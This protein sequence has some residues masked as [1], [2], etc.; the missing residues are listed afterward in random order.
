MED[1]INNQNTNPA[2]P[3]WVDKMLEFFCAPQLL[4]EVQGDMFE[5]YG[6]WVE[7]Y[8]ERKARRLYI[9][10]ALKFFRPFA[11]KKQKKYNATSHHTM[12]KNYFQIAYRNLAKHIGYTAINVI[13]LSVGLTASLFIALYIIHELSYD[14]DH[15]KADRIYRVETQKMGAEGA[16]N[17]PGAPLGVAAA[18]RQD[19]PE[20]EEVSTIIF[21]GN[22]LIS[23]TDRKASQ[24][25]FK[26]AVAFAEPEL[27]E[28]FDYQWVVGNPRTS[29]TEPNS[30]I[31]T[32]SYV[33][34]LFGYALDEDLSSVIGKVIQ[35]NLDHDLKVVGVLEDFAANTSFPFDIIVSMTTLKDL[36]L[37]NWGGW[38]DNHQTYI[39]LAEGTDPR[40]VEVQFPV[41]LEKYKGAEASKERGHRLLPLKE[42]HFSYNY[43]GRQADMNN[44]YALGI[45]GLFLLITA[46]INFINLATA[47]VSKRAKEVGV[48]KVLGSSRSQL[49]GQFMSE[50]VLVTLMAFLMAAGLVS[51]LLP[52][53]SLL[54]DINLSFTSLLRPNF[55]FLAIAVFVLVSLLSGLYPAW[56]LS[57]FR[58]VTAL[59]NKTIYKQKRGFPLR[60]SMVT[61]QFII[62]QVLVIATI[63]AISQMQLF[64]NTD[65]GFDTD[66]IIT[67]ELPKSQPEKL[68]LL[69]HQLLQFAEVKNVSFSFNSA[70]AESNFMGDVVYK[71]DSGEVSIHTQLKLVD[72][73]FLDTYGINL[74]AGKALKEGDTTGQVLVNEVFIRKMGMQHPEEAIGEFID[75]SY[76]RFIITGV[77]KDFHVNSLHQNIDP[78]IIIV[79]PQHYQQAG[80][81]IQALAV[82]NMQSTIQHIQEV[83]SANFPDQLFNYQFL[84]ETL[85]QAYEKENKAMQLLYVFAGIA[86][87][88]S[89]LGLYGLVSF[90]AVQRTKEVGI[91]KILGASVGH[92]VQLFAK[93]FM[94]LVALAFVISVPTGY[95]LMSRW[96]QDFA[97]QTE[98]SWW[99]F[100]LAGTLAMVIALFTVSF[101]SIKAALTNPVDSL[102]NE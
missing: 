68:E 40:E 28:V 98:L 99:I 7:E 31:L 71:A 95:Y 33:R 56:V 8:G 15:T 58:P 10:N 22:Q 24:A 86:I 81:K 30:I 34:K 88:I 57:G 5:M 20:I 26:E 14:R 69:R 11:L 76:P 44:L 3:F 16:N 100:A 72:A 70:S 1:R 97:Y 90:T 60:Q 78:T 62:S 52:Y 36:E 19:F 27:F 45:V 18:L 75:N 43:G 65:L 50:T 17:F 25:K 53:A 101:Q 42:V 93:E 84:D 41:M 74:L 46:C 29:L 82:G 38:S 64:R 66:A 35:L 91:R 39:V 2:P 4:E 59:K 94:V 83:W 102:R 96:L 23:T 47:Q 51:L 55:V 80:I 6:K 87:F 92:I 85:A 12:L 77:V 67:L 54:M 89:C 21:N 9:W 61:L 37:N 48:R 73:H 49:A 79:S 13:G 32:E 63:V